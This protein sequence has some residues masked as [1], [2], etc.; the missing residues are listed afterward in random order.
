VQ[1][2]RGAPQHPIQA[3]TSVT[4]TLVKGPPNT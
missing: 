4:V 1:A 3:A 2:L